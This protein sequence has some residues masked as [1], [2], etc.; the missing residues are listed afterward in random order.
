MSPLRPAR[1]AAGQRWRGGG[2][3][4]SE[5]GARPPSAPPAPRHA[6][7]RHVRH[8]QHGPPLAVL[9]PAP[10]ALPLP[11]HCGLLAVAAHWR[12]RGGDDDRRCCGAACVASR[13]APAAPR[14]SQHDVTAGHRH[15]HRV[16]AVT[17]SG[18]AGCAGPRC[19]PAAQSAQLVAAAESPLH[20][21]GVGP[22]PPQV[23]TR[24][25]L[26]GAAACL[27]S[28]SASGWRGNSHCCCPAQRLPRTTTMIGAA[29][30]EGRAGTAR[31]GAH[32]AAPAV[33]PAG[34]R[35]GRNACRWRSAGPPPQPPPRGPPWFGG[36]AWG[37]PAPR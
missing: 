5:V 19:C 32:A 1:G 28:A 3:P 20:R 25:C 36:G 21:R 2:G 11:Q 13:S 33:E 14:A 27:A 22:S 37:R 16:P 31:G 18:G 26:L 4:A 6:R 35:R 12:H 15:R 8:R 23:T 10:L 17:R 34:P 7:S 29:G 24:H 30:A 9:P